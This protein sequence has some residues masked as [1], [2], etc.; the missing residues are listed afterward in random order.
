MPAN[1]VLT[2]DNDGFGTVG[3][4]RQTLLKQ[5]VAGTN[6]T[7]R[8]LSRVYPPSQCPSYYNANGNNSTSPSNTSPTKTPYQFTSG[9]LNN[10]KSFGFKYGYIETRVKM[11]KGFALWPAL[12]LRDWGG[13]G[14]EIDVFE[15]FDRSSRTFRTSYWWGNGSNRSTEND[16]GDI[17]LSAGGVPCRQHVPI[18]A[19]SSS[20]SDCSLANGVDLS[21]G[22]HTIGLNWTA[23]KYELFLDGVKRWTSPAGADVADTYNHLILNLA[24]GNNSYEFD[25]VD[26]PVK[27]VQPEP[28]QLLVLP[29]ADHRVGLRPGLAAGHRPRRLHPTRLR[30]TAPE[31]QRA[32]LRDARVFVTGRRDGAAL[33]SMHGV[34]SHPCAAAVRLRRD[35][36]AEDG[37][38]AGRTSTSSTSGSATRTSRRRRSRSRSWPR[39]PATRATTG[40]RRPAASRACASR[41]PISTSAGSASSS[42]PRPR[43]AS[44]IGAK[45]GFSHLMWVLL[46]PGDTALVPSPSYP[47][48]IWGPILAGAGVHY[49]R[50]GPDQDFFANLHAAWEQAWPRPRVVVMSF[51]HNP[52]G[53]V[54]RPRV[55]DPHGASSRATHDV[56]LVHD[57]AYAELGF[58]G[59]EPPSLLAGARREGRRGRDLQPH[60]E[61]LDGRLARRVHARQPRGRRRARP[62]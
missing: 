15:G 34:P 23:T 62:G 11:P 55:H 43:R 17:G 32:A 4:L 38:P 1:S 47:I 60:E 21:A 57:F 58:D 61:L 53:D 25:W 50:L 3:V 52:T 2:T 40:T 22:Y 19:T 31:E 7:V 46:G 10:S 41:S 18:P 33:P 44:T 30:L 9:M 16:G 27:P 35:R 56:L 36:R 45:E 39:R 48:H 29:E 12:W 59:Y 28:V 51:P 8:T 37:R 42:T 13:W 49:V 14:Y 54:R 5:A 24:L 6:Y 20:P 26:E